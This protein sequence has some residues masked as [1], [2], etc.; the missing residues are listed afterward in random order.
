M[1]NASLIH[2]LNQFHQALVDCRQLYLTGAKLVAGASRNSAEPPDARFVQ[3]MDELHR[4]LLIKLFI[5][6]CGVDHI[7]T[8]TEE[9]F[10][11]ILVQHLWQQNL[12]KRQLRE[13]I[14][15]F[16]EDAEQLSWQQLVEPFRR[17]RALQGQTAELE[18]C[19]M[20]I[21]NLLAK[22]DGNP[23]SLEMDKLKQIQCEIISYLGC[24]VRPAAPPTASEPIATQSARFSLPPPQE[25]SSVK[26][27]EPSETQVDLPSLLEELDRLVGM[28][29]VKHEI[30]SLVNY[31][32]VQRVRSGAGLPETKIGLHMVFC[33]NPGTGKTTVARFLGQIYGAMGVLSR[34]HL[35]ETDRS[36][37]VAQYAGQTA[38]KTNAIVDA[39]LDGILFIDEAYSLITDQGNDPYGFEAIQVLLKR[40]E[41][42]RDRLVV[43]LAGY[44]K[45]MDELLNSNPG[46]ASRFSRRID[47]A[48]YSPRELGE[49]LGQMCEFNQY[50]L[51][52]LVQAKVLVGFDWL[53]RNRNDKF[54]NGRMVR[55][56]FERAIR[57]L[58]N[59]IVGV[60]QLT[61]D[62]LTK[63]E[64]EDFELDGVP[65][66]VLALDQLEQRRFEAACR[67]CGI[68][69]RISA[70]LLGRKVRCKSCQSQ[71]AVNWCTP[72]AE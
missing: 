66:E 56:V 44:P 54:G 11:G 36:G 10:A 16:E 25:K 51:R 72:V 35:I 45:P 15:R 38:P 46:L 14:E 40:M 59:R 22:S 49:I 19:L 34:G 69:S 33:G 55:N 8:E 60:P 20:R 61:R 63:F 47:F 65:S 58:S 43:V 5:S 37:L 42:Q 70:D 1:S 41:D 31:L 13:A 27:V 28:D 48:D 62:M 18:T 17:Y 26:R 2:E 71:F 6:I 68:A 64:L 50:T 21:G 4:G 3:T 12:S 9:K 32:K 7:W 29:A 39:A 57:K 67:K 30:K 24:E 52:Q 23:S 53:Y